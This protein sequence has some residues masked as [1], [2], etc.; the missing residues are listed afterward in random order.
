MSRRPAHSLVVAGLLALAPVAHAVL[1]T[2]GFRAVPVARTTHPISALAVAP[3]GRLFAA[4]QGLGQPET[5]HNGQAEIR[6]FADY[7]VTDGSTMDEGDVWATLD[8]VHLDNSDEGLLG[9]ALAPD[10]ATS[11]LVYVH[12]TTSTPGPED[13]DVHDQEI[14]VY[15]ENADGL[16]DY[17]GTVQTGLELASASNRRNGGELTFGADGCLYLGNGDG[18]SSDRWSAQITTGRDRPNG[19]ETTAWCEDVCLGSAEYPDRLLEEHDGL[20]NHAGKILRLAVEGPSIAQGAGGAPVAAQPLLF[21]GGF[22]DP[23]GI[24]SHPLTGQIY[25]A[26]RADSLEAEVALV[27]SGSNHGWPCL[28]G[29]QVKEGC[30]AGLTPDDVYANHPSWRRPLVSHPGSNEVVSGLA[31][32]TGLGYPAE[33]YGDV[34]Y[35]LRNG[36]RIYRLDLEAPCFVP[37]TDS[38]AALP[39]HDSDENDGD[40]R[41]LY[42]MDEDGETEFVSFQ[43]F[44]DIAQ[45]PSPFGTDVLYVAARRDNND[46]LQA[47][48][49]VFRLEY[50][51]TFAPYTGALGRVGDECFAGSENP[52]TRPSCLPPGGACPGAPDG[53]PCDDRDVCNGTEECASGV[54]VHV[55]AT[56][57]DGTACTPAR[58]CMA[59]G[60]CGAGYCVSNT[61]AA[62]GTACAD[63]DPC[64]GLETCLAG[65]CQPGAGP[66]PLA[67]KNLKVQ[68]GPAGTLD[69][70]AGMQPLL[71][72][73]PA[74]RDALL[75]TLSTDGGEVYRGQIEHP[76][77]DGL[78]SRSK[79]G[80][81]KLK[82]TTGAHDGITRVLVKARKS[83]TRLRLKAQNVDLSGVQAAPLS[84]RVVV[85]DQCFEAAL[86][87]RP[88]AKGLRCA[89]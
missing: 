57:A 3:D 16:G 19:T 66:A 74:T 36:A 2:P 5:T 17:L 77:S 86:A 37:A 1:D 30:L 67:V 87:C 73:E 83:G 7:A 27:E 26:E 42:D 13:E 76:E 52:F 15:R 8:E 61:I 55:G 18:G 75:L 4:V 88:K 40:F 82:D 59:D 72:L 31:A 80:R 35:L 48:T 65:L 46:D 43:N 69:L 89:P 56:A 84:A 50:A 29:E 11:G 58:A 68:G 60:T 10:F 71:P 47:D 6:V 64:N 39:F 41:A 79:S 25:V 81:A 62:D 34:F 53:T 63:A 28:E 38:L 45:G 78:W 51:T 49:V 21:A 14:R 54:C 23:M 22:R 24:L 33:F 20:L 32:Y 12:V 70:N 85:G 44:I 9:L